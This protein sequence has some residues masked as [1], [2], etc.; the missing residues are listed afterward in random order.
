MVDIVSKLV[1][2]IVPIYN[3]APYLRDCLDSVRSQSHR[4]M[5]VILV[6]DGSTDNSAEIAEEYVAMDSRFQLIRQANAGLSAAR[7]TGIPYATGDYI[8]FLDSDDVLASFAYEVLVGACE[9]TGSQIATGSVHRLNSRG[10]HLGYPHWEVFRGTKLKTHISEHKQLLLDRTIWNKIFSKPFF[11]E[12]G[13]RFPP[14][15][16]YEDMPVSLPAHARANHI[17]MVD[18]PIYFWREREGVDRSITQLDNDVKNMVDRFYCV[19]LVRQGLDEA[20]YSD[21]RKI[22]EEYAVWE[23]L[24]NYQKFLPTATQEYRDTYLNLANQ[25]VEQIGVDVI[26]RLPQRRE[27][28][29]AVRDRDIDALIELVDADVRPKRNKASRSRS[30]LIS[31]MHSVE[32]RDGKLHIEGYAYPQGK[33]MSK[34]WSAARMFWL[35]ER[36]SR[37]VQLKPALPHRLAGPVADS[38]DPELSYDWS[39]FSLTVDPKS[40]RRNGQWRSGT[41][42]FAVAATDGPRMR[43]DGLR[44]GELSLQLPPLD[45]A[46]GV[47]LMPVQSWGV[48]QLRV[49]ASRTSVTAIRRVGDD[50]VFE[51]ETRSEPGSNPV[52]RLS[53]TR[54]L[55]AFSA[56]VTTTP[57]SSGGVAFTATVPLSRVGVDDDT[58]NHARGLFRQRFTVELGWDG[59]KPE[60]VVAATDLP[61]VRERYSSDEVYTHVSSAG[62]LYLNTRPAGPVVTD[63][64]WLA[65]GSLVLGGDS[66]G[67]TGD[68]LVLRVRGRRRD[69]R[70]PMITDGDRWTATLRPDHSYVAGATVAMVPG[71]WDITYRPLGAPYDV[72]PPLGFAEELLHRMPLTTEGPT[73][74]QYDLEGT[75]DERGGIRIHAD[76]AHAEQGVNGQQRLRQRYSDT[77]ATPV[78]RNTLLM[79]GAEGRRFA[80][81]LI[82]LKN[83]LATRPDAPQ[84]L[85]TAELGQDVPA[86]VERITLHS[87]RW[88]EALTTSRTVVTN[89]D[90]PRWFRRREG[91]TVLHVAQGWPV[92]HFGASA[93]GHP[94]GSTLIEQ[95]AADTAQWS[96]LVS[97][98]PAATPV[99][100]REYGYSGEVLEFG[101]PSVDLLVDPNRSA[102]RA[103]AMQRLGV[104]PAKRV[105]V[106]LPSWRTQEMRQ[107]GW[108]NPGRLLDLPKVA[109]GLGEGTVLLARRHPALEDDISGSRGLVADVSR[110][111]NAAELLVVADV[112]I[113]DY[114]AALV[115]FTATGRPILLYVPDLDVFSRAPGLEIDLH[116]DAPGPLLFQ[117]EEVVAALAELD[118]VA[119]EHE[120]A[121]KAFADRY[122]ESADGR[123]SARVV[124][125]LVARS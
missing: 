73:G 57:Q 107:R 86:G 51:G 105:A 54:G 19:D 100:R 95:I 34:P 13:W 18:L 111:A 102:I 16:L 23:E 29:R 22:Y 72:T 6:D 91:Q 93:V 44:T 49:V 9:Q 76:L 118:T 81:D 5:Q 37:R 2:V 35:R 36:G 104:D 68:V 45:V 80:D 25:Y 106:Y 15:R 10:H 94:L 109:E 62:Y 98:G 27:H 60:H 78:L 21:L 67:A 125:W 85:W 58:H 101:R 70:V 26:D 7:N 11:D 50:L 90:L 84:V 113:T 55:A 114:S 108:S 99:L 64:R 38:A 119:A 47:R 65:D 52:L 112:L 56:P 33:G 89:D 66:S 79:D 77:S 123:A 69:V 122:L 4:E 59:A 39:G 17:S 1:S 3:V 120:G 124:D 30:G 31:G 83:E 88:Y 117:S 82:A 28:W 40:L 71:L 20:G 61:P 32:W 115:D 75:G 42:S 63:A 116:T 74:V 8:A 48:L 87:E 12:H 92:K 97:P 103:A 96:A 46:P 14:G 43:R 121:Y 24:S 41:W 53:R 110:Y